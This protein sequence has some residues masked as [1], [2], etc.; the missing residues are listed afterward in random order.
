MLEALSSLK[1]LCLPAQRLPT[2]GGYPGF[3]REQPTTLKELRMNDVE[4]NS[5]PIVYSTHSFEN[6][7]PFAVSRHLPH[8]YLNPA[9]VDILDIDFYIQELL[10]HRNIRAQVISQFSRRE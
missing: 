10:N 4:Y 1:G 9:F 3:A 8:V 2:L 5:E 7:A 6:F